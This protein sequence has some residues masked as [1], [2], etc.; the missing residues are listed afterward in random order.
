MS[1]GRE[2]KSKTGE[3]EALEGQGEETGQAALGDQVQQDG[4]NRSQPFPGGSNFR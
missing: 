1:C 3:T 2:T 4:Q